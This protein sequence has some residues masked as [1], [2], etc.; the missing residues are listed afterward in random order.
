MFNSYTTLLISV[1]V[2]D[3]IDIL[4][5]AV[6]LYQLY[7]LIRGTAAINI[8][9]GIISIYL[10]WKLVKAFQME[11]LGEILGQVISVGIIALIVVFQQEVRQFLLMVGNPSYF[12]K[13]FLKIFFDRWKM[14][15]ALLHDI[16]EIINSCEKMAGLYTGAL[17]VIA[18]RNDLTHYMVTGEILDARISGH[19]IENIFFKNSPLHDG[20]IIIHGGR[21]KA[22]RCILPI[23]HSPNIPS[24]FGL[25]H[26]AAIGITEI[27]DSI[28]IVVSEQTGKISYCT[29]GKIEFD[30][31]LFDLKKHLKHE[32]NI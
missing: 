7:N 17:I 26:R 32:L 11:L 21:I 18:K 20:A 31:S 25:R 1:R 23:S 8:F 16:D 10:I 14:N 27:T 5:V 9:I 22:A 28:T 4:L 15:K 13:G 12:R 6:L 2:I 29:H 3:I 19:L 24:R 30:I